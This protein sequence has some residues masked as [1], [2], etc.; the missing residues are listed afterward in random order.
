[1]RRLGYL[2]LSVRSVTE[3]SCGYCNTCLMVN[4]SSTNWEANH[5]IKNSLSE[6]I[7]LQFRT[8]LY[9]AGILIF[10]PE[11]FSNMRCAIKFFSLW[12]P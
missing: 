4:G 5:F 3:H 1:M 11:V 6:S 2:G 8:K 9:Y 7:S 10:L 12:I